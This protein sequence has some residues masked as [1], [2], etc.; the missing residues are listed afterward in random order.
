MR[1]KSSFPQNTSDLVVE[2]WQSGHVFP[3]CTSSMCDTPQA[4]WPERACFFHPPVPKSAT[5][6]HFQEIQT[7]AKSITGKHGKHML[8]KYWT[9]K[10]HVHGIELPREKTT[11]TAPRVA[12]LASLTRVTRKPGKRSQ[13]KRSHES[14]SGAGGSTENLRCVV[15][16]VMWKTTLLIMFQIKPMICS[17]VQRGQI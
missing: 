9:Q 7:F 12:A 2:N 16:S 5:F 4:L 3:F 11:R 14:E 10:K 1:N 17:Q 6:S 15:R 8:A 13:E